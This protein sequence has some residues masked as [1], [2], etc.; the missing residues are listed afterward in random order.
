M[1][2]TPINTKKQLRY[3]RLTGFATCSSKRGHVDRSVWVGWSVYTCL[4]VCL[5]V[6]QSI[7]RSLKFHKVAHSEVFMFI[8]YDGSKDNLDWQ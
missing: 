3:Q 5:F 2:N 6:G 8:Q 7:M 4:Y 1:Q